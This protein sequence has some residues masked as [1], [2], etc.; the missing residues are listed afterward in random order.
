MIVI[1]GGYHEGGGQIVRTAVGLSALTGKDLRIDNI[2]AKRPKPGLSYQHVCAVN[3]VAQMC[4]ARTKGVFV[5]SKTLEFSPGKY[6]GLKEIKVKIP[7]AGAIGLVLQPLIIAAFGVKEKITIEIEGGA[8]FGKWAPPATYIQNVFCRAISAFGCDV[9]VDVLRH[10][11]YPK[12]GGLTQVG[13]EP[14]KPKSADLV[15]FRENAKSV[16]G[17]SVASRDLERRDVARRQAESAKKIL[18]EAGVFGEVSIEERYVDSVSAGSGIVL[19]IGGNMFLGASS[20]GEVSKRAEDVGKKAAIELID[21]YKT[22]AYVD[23]YLCD[24]L[25]PFLAMCGGRIKTSEI[26][27]HTETNVWV[28]EK[29]MDVSFDVNGKD[30][31]VSLRQKK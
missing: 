14:L 26:T 10:G 22:E 8:S 9:K 5:G 1:N 27:K 25:I 7:T 31:I 28:V 29:F 24:Q 18:C 20:V 17:L 13:I 19:W 4:C 30:K 16:N 23:K 11:F 15:S 2:R 6:E 3:A 21:D 12:G